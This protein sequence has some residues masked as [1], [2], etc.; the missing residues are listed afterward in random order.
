MIVPNH[1]AE[2][3][4]KLRENGLTLR[5]IGELE[6]VSGNR[7]MQILRQRQYRAKRSEAREME[8]EALK[9]KLETAQ[10]EHA[11][12]AVSSP[13]LSLMV[14][15]LELSV[16]SANCLRNEYIVTLGDLVQRSEW[17]LLRMPNF[18]RKSLNEIKEMLGEFGL[19]LAPL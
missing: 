19:C 1:R 12:L 5:A 6:G 4:A 3:I 2:R 7:I 14:G 15:N 11:E 10:A 13:F 9:K 16:R 17:E 18:G 8:R